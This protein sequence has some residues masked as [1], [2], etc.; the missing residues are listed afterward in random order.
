LALACYRFLLF[1]RRRNKGPR[2]A[3]DIL[4]RDGILLNEGYSMT[5]ADK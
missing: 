1:A 4:R 5:E 2:H 3:L